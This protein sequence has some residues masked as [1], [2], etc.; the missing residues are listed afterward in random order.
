M[1]ALHYAHG[2]RYFDS[3][4][5]CDYTDTFKPIDTRLLYPFATATGIQPYVTIIDDTGLFNNQEEC[6]EYARRWYARNIKSDYGLLIISFT[7]GYISTVGGSH[8][9]EQ[10]NL[11]R[12][13]LNEGLNIGY[14]LYGLDKH[15][16]TYGLE[17][18][19]ENVDVI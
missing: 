14:E 11:I 1:S 2:P 15:M 3:G 10:Y 8:I 18:V 4:C 7:D 13:V 17:Y 5:I 19:L 16:F 12:D 6:D 9:Q